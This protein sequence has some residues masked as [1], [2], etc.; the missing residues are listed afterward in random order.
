MLRDKTWKFAAKGS[1]ADDRS[2]AH[3]CRVQAKDADI[4]SDIPQDRAQ[5][6]AYLTSES[7]QALWPE[8]PR[9]V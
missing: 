4:R 5:R 8:D 2:S 3:K 7:C 1:K 9:R 6:N